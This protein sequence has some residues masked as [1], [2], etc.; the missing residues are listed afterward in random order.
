MRGERTDLI[1]GFVSPVWTAQSEVNIS[2]VNMPQVDTLLAQ[3]DGMSDQ[4]ARLLL[5]QQA[6]QLLVNRVAAIPLFQTMTSCCAIGVFRLA[7]GA[8]GCDATFCLADSISQTLAALFLLVVGIRPMR[9]LRTR[10]RRTERS[11]RA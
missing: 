10:M 5:Y 1:R 4:A 11:M 8:D 6:E 7:C 2:N 9:I 3:A